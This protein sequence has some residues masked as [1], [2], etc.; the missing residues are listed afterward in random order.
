MTN[1]P[2]PTDEHLV[3]LSKDGNLDAFNRLVDRYQSAVYSLCFRL[4]GERTA[5]EDAAQETFLAAYRAIT[6]FQEGSFRSWLFRIAAN[7]ARDELRRRGRRPRTEPLTPRDDPE[8]PAFDPP[9]PSPGPA[10]ALDHAALSAGLEHAL[11]Q[12][13]F[14]QR[15]A[16]LLADLHGFAY[17]EI[18]AMTGTSLGTVKSRIFRGRERLRAII[19][20][21]PEL[22]GRIQ[23]PDQR[24]DS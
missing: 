23:R 7:Q 13:P 14:D 10:E 6:R 12:L 19:A 2:E 3:S 16:V 15:Q 4:L 20:R 18:A 21:N 1:P 22:F 24:G 11:L 17:D 5:A 8:P 9:D